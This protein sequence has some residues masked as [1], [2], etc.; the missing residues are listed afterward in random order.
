MRTLTFGLMIILMLVVPTLAATPRNSVDIARGDPVL[1]LHRS[2]TEF[3][4]SASPELNR[5]LLAPAPGGYAV[6]QFRD[7]ITVADR[8]ALEGVGVRILEYL[9]DYAYLVAGHGAQLDAAARLPRVHRRAPFTRADKLAPALLRGLI[10]GDG[11][12][13]RVRVLGWPGEG[14]AVVAD[15]REAGFGETVS[16]D[17]ATLLWLANIA[18]VRWIEPVGQPR[19]LNDH[20]RGIMNID[21]VHQEGG[22]FGS[23]Q[24]IAVADSGLDT[25]D[26]GTLSPDFAGR[27][28]A[29]HVLSAGAQWD[30][31]H[32]H[33][34]HVA[35]SAVGA[36][37]QSGADPATHDYAGS[38]AG[39]A[40][41]AGLV[42]QAFETL[43]NGLIIGLDPDYYQ[44]FDQA[45]ADGA[46]LHSDSWGDLTG[47]ITDTEAAFGGYP[48]GAQRADA[49]LW[50]HP[51]MAIF[52][53]AGNS[54]ADG[55]PDPLFGFCLD[56]DGVVDPDSLLAPGTAKNVIT[57]G[58]GESDRNTG[59]VSGFP[60]LL[61]NPCFVTQPIATDT[62]SDD[63]NGMAAFSSRGPTD[64]GR[65]KP[66][67]VAPGTNIVSNHSH[68]PG[69]T[70]L[71]APHETNPHYVYSGGTSMATPLVT[72]AGALVR[73]WLNTRGFAGPSG[74]AIKALLLN[75][76]HDM[77]PGQYGTG[78]PQEIPVTRPNPV[79]GWGRVDLGF[80]GA[81]APFQIWLDD[82][83]AGLV[84]GQVISYTH[85]ALRPLEVIT[86]SMPLRIMLAWT[87]PP[88]SLSAS[89]QLVNDLD[90]VVI[91]PGGQR[92]YGNDATS[93][94]RTNNVEGIVV[95][96]PP[97]GLY[98]IGVSG[99]N[100]PIA[101]Q[102]YALIVA[103]PLRARASLAVSKWPDSPVASLGQTVT[104]TYRVTNTG[105]ITLTD[106]K[107]WDDR[108]GPVS[109]D[110]GTLFP[111]QSAG[112]T[113]TYTI[114]PDDLPG[115][116]V[117]R[118]LVTGTGGG[119]PAPVV[120]VTDT[121]QAAVYLTDGAAV[122]VTKTPSASDASPGET[123]T[124]TYRVSNTGAITLTNVAGWDDRLGS[125]PFDSGTLAPNQAT[126]GTLTY[127]IQPD[128]LLGPVVN[129][130]L[131]SGTAGGGSAPLVTVTDTAQAAVY[132]TH[133][134]AV[135]VTKTPSASSA[136]P[137][138][139]IT[140]TYRVSN[141]GKIP[142][143]DVAG[144]DDRLGAIL[145]DGVTLAPNQAT[146]G[147]LT[148]TIQ[149]DDLPGPVV[150]SVLVTG[151]FGGG[152]APLV[153][154][155]DT[156]QAAVYLTHGA[157]VAV[158]KAPRAANGDIGETITYTYRVSNTG[159]VP[160]TNVA[161]WDDQLGSIP[162]D[163]VTLAPSQATGG[164]LT[165]TIQSDDLPGPVVNLVLVTGTF[166][167]GS[168]PLVTV[169]D[170]AQAAVFLTG[171]AAMAVGKIPGIA[172]A[173]P[174]QTITYTYLVTN[175]GM[176]TLTDVMGWDDRLGPVP[177]GGT[178]IDPDQ[179][180][181][182]ILTYTVRISD[183]M[184]VLVNTVFVTA[185]TAT[186]PPFVLQAT[187]SVILRQG[188]DFSVLLPLVLKRIP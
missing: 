170:T 136:S 50:D 77:A 98:Q 162:F 28:V 65:V 151:T 126:G 18:S 172:S 76:T 184:E 72:G 133:G 12:A 69:A 118:V 23:G 75:T 41:E 115:P 39:V 188:A 40:P 132:L 91:G 8:A 13:W 152:S 137:G 5:E 20:A 56:G 3:A 120:T 94:D 34:T 79:A 100:V 155:T 30:D 177:F 2:A 16:A 157:A 7:P 80:I 127:T 114:Q 129:R 140:Y 125:I 29:T 93:G 181:A 159:K 89:A 121:A 33:G 10:A 124:Y 110:S 63:P 141:T 45:Y 113:L 38:F 148:Y 46:R 185:S 165:Y 142:L 173:G 111:Y 95:P 62:V 61:L 51:D 106:V 160:L 134:A 27:I 64:D 156:A 138:E 82:H 103:G 86:D 163:G 175:T 144:W 131:V 179:G 26:M 22:L 176:V 36:G 143:T 9:P 108:L 4:T 158:T 150:N 11:A 52:V 1:R 107:G 81:P 6:I 135:V 73:Q 60:W 139:T 59:G 182:A 161:G 147:T 84:T 167:G 101:S 35:G 153:T 168:A 71:W 74:A 128:D 109:L 78:P 102:P 105:S 53:A 15:L 25:G 97:L 42:V 116:V 90:L 19:L 130:A 32:G 169:T 70:Q 187:A 68:A 174:G 58:A 123:I 55:T 67:L 57:V 48:Y 112:G 87:D 44:L 66:D 186:G 88:A 164:T 117:N 145:P 85:T 122:A 24:V 47:L 92:Y 171:G 119:G 146:G 17:R 37:V 104:Y 49:F 83:G 31:N 166:G 183:L 43:T 54:G 21:G 180:A 149:P 178:A 154:V 14:E 99:F 96:D